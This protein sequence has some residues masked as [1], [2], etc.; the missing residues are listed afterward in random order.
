MTQPTTRRTWQRMAAALLPV[1]GVGA[2]AACGGG[3]S[4]PPKSLS[5]SGDKVAVTT[6]QYGLSSLCIVAHEANNPSAASATYFATP[7]NSLHQLAAALGGSR[8]AALLAGMEAFERAALNPTAPTAN[9]MTVQTSN[10]L[11]GLVDGDLI[12]LKLPKVKCSAA[13]ASTTTTVG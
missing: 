3:S 7:Y 4:A 6:V 10:G 9:A 11:L 13:Y 8:R 2:L 1:L 5:L 12:S